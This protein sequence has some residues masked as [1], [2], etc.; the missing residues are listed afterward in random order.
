MSRTRMRL[1]SRSW[2]E[3]GVRLSL[4]DSLGLQF[5]TF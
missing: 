2:I 1:W 4:V 3:E 5:Y